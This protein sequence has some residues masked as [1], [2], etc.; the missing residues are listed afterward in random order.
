[1]STPKR[2]RASTPQEQIEGAFHEGIELGIK[3]EEARAGWRDASPLPTVV[4]Q[5]LPPPPPP[6]PK[7]EDEESD[8]DV[9]ADADDDGEAEGDEA[10]GDEAGA[11][12]RRATTA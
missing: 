12:R 8:A 6:P 10:E 4:G 2:R 1:M 7:D 5:P 11:T 9:N 3:L